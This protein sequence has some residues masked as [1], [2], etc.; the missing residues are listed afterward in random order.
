MSK[1]E[2]PAVLTI[3]GSDSGGG[4]GVQADLK[5][6]AAL[7]CHGLSVITCVTAQN[8]NVITGVEPCSAEMIRKQL[9]AVNAFRPRAAKTGMLFSTEIIKVVAEFF[10]S[11]RRV[12]LVVDPVAVATSG[13]TLL[14]SGAIATLKADLLP[15]ATLVTP[16]V[17]EAEALLR[18][19]IREPEDLRIAARAFHEQFGCAALVK[20]GHLGR[21]NVAIDVLHDGATEFLLEAPRAK[22]IPTHGTGCTYASAIA[23]L[24][25]RGESLQDAVFGAKKL[26]TSAI[27]QSVKV[28]PFSVLDPLLERLKTRQNA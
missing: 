20:G 24:L 5:T 6:F 16:N 8:P 23:A 11:E 18:I 9:E 27:Y 21:S 7:R 15:L 17:P 1:R 22:N 14:L 12:A 2:V 13:A 19:K 4:S 26:I 3:A 25:A 10:R 28:G